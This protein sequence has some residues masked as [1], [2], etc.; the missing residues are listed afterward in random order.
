MEGISLL[1]YDIGLEIEKF[2]AKEN[3][4]LKRS[5]ILI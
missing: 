5:M 2:K 3:S 1:T 4:F